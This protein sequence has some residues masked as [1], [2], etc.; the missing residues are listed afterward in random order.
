MIPK[1][2]LL[3]LLVAGTAATTFAQT[4]KIAHRS[5]SGKASTFTID[6]ADN[7]G[8]TPEM[9][10]KEM[11]RKAKADSVRMKQKADSLSKQPKKDTLSAPVTRTKRKRPASTKITTGSK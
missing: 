10:R 7:F 11:E 1:M 6:G 9:K 3:L 5:H 8:L 2:L 4:K